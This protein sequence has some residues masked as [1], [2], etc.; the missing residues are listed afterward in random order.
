[1]N[2]FSCCNSC[3]LARS[4]KQT[5]TNEKSILNNTKLRFLVIALL[6]IVPFEILSLYSLH[7]P[8]Y[9]ELP[10]FLGIILWFGRDVFKSAFRSLIKF[11]VSN[12]NLLMTIAVIG[13]FYI[14][15]WEEAVIIVILFSL[16]EELERYGVEKSRSALQKLVS[17]S[18]K[19][20]LIKGQKNPVFIETIT[21]GEIIVVSDGDQIPLDGEIVKGSSLIDEATITGEPLPKSKNIGDTVYAGSFNGGGYLEIE[22]TKVSKDTMLA[23]IIHLTCEA[24]EKKASSQKFIEKFAKYYTPFILFGSL[25][26]VLIPVFV[27][28]KP[29][30][31]WFTQ[32]LTLLVISCPCALVISTPVAVFSAIGNATQRGVLIKGGQFIEAMGKIKVIAFDKT[33]TL[34]KGEPI[35][36]DIVSFNGYTKEEVLACAAGIEAFSKH[37][38]AKSIT[39]KA[40]ELGIDVHAFENFQSLMGKG[41]RGDCLVCADRH[42]CLGNRKF[43]S[44]EHNIEEKVLQKVDELESQGKTTIVMSAVGKIKGVI[45]VMDEIRPESKEV[46]AELKGLNVNSV[47]L[48][49]DNKSSAVYV[50]KTLGINEIRAELLPENKVQELSKLKEKY[51]DIGMIGDGVNDAAALAFATVGIAMGAISSDVAMESSDI[52]LMNMNLELLPFLVRL[53]RVCRRTIQMN[54]GAAIIVKVLFIGFAFAGLGNLALA[55]FADVGIT[56]LVILNSLRLFRYN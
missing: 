50:A 46:I 43:V 51:G 15:E 16:G 13:A 20:A 9:I 18:P 31:P 1:M 28:G 36:S 53:G 48:T 14:N 5:S 23:K 25:L 55:I 21:I 45:G 10:L 7:F 26:L 33:R 47:M 6:I 30:D 29:F 49:G 27:F 11:N 8:N 32:A 34:T 38:V 2:K 17:N 40:N 44:E 35:V 37:P 39:I 24:A 54:I 3:D 56:L 22:V 12:I 4:N 42:H 52:A 19:T 41:L